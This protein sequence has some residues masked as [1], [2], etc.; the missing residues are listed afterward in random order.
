MPTGNAKLFEG[1][2]NNCCGRVSCHGCVMYHHL[3][4]GA[5][6]ERF[7]F[8]FSGFPSVSFYFF[9]IKKEKHLNIPTT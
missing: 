8:F 9:F 2:N 5:R 4:C 7:H 3:I 1:M 6:R